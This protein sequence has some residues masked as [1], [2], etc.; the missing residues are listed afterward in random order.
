MLKVLG[1]KE[2]VMW[3][4]R[5]SSDCF[6]YLQLSVTREIPKITHYVVRMRAVSEPNSRIILQLYESTM[7]NAI[8]QLDVALCYKPE[9]RGFDSRWCHLDFSLT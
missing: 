5:A 8:M 9:G 3:I 6:I 4:R 1:L 7:G 2:A